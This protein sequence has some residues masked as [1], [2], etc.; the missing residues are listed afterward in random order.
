[1]SAN[2]RVRCLPHH[3]VLRLEDAA[4]LRVLR[5]SLWLTIDNE[6]DDIVLER[7]QVYEHDGHARLLATPLHEAAAVS[8]SARRREGPGLVNW[9]PLSRAFGAAR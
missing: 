3:G 4:T 7:G 9:W 5:G 2:A 8:V 6:V 1:M